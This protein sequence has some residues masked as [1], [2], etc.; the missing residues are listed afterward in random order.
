MNEKI[1][2]ISISGDTEAIDRGLSL[3]LSDLSVN[4]TPDGYPIKAVR[5]DSP[6]LEI[7]ADERGAEIIFSEKCQ[8]FRAMGLLLEHMRDGETVISIKETPRFKMNG[9]MV[10]VSQGCNCIKDK[11]YA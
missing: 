3:L 5:V 7:K 9:A 10:D 1:I 8:F 11:N 6:A 2:N 4:I